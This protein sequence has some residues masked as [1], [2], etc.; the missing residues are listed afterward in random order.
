[1]SLS[2]VSEVSLGPR[3]KVLYCQLSTCESVNCQLEL[4]CPL[5]HCHSI[6]LCTLHFPVPIDWLMAV[7]LSRAEP[8][9]IIFLAD[10]NWQLEVSS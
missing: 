5:A 2:T 4:N 10:G 9:L 3:P 8:E 6:V 7:E 1:M